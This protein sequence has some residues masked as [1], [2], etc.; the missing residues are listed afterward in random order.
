MLYNKK[1]FLLTRKG[2][3]STWLEPLTFWM[4]SRAQSIV[5]E[6]PSYIYSLG[7]SACPAS[8]N[9]LEA[10]FKGALTSLSTEVIANIEPV[11]G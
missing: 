4:Q 3:K 2:L 11:V 8:N 5:F 6:T 1:P 7:P 10:K 9:F